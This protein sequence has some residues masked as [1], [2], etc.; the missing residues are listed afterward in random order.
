MAISFSFLLASAF[1]GL[2]VMAT[3]GL[4]SPSPI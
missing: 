3:G 1:G 4:M 2:L